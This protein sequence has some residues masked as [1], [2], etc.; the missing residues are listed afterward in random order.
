MVVE[1]L[2]DTDDDMRMLALQQIRE[3]VP[4]EDA[5]KRFVAVLPELPPDVQIRLIDA[6]GERGD[7]AARPVILKMLNS[8]SMAMRVMAARTLSAVLYRHQGGAGAQPQGYRYRAAQEE[9]HCLYGRL[10]IGQV[11]AGL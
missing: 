1:L 11:L 3:S 10:G 5:T 7:P 9:A 4:G 6:L 2:K 8:E